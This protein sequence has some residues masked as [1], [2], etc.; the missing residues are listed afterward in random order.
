[1]LAR[2]RPPNRSTVPGSTARNDPLLTLLIPS[3]AHPSMTFIKND[4]TGESKRRASRAC[5]AEETLLSEFD[6]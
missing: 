6:G 3:T 2:I 4:H 1:M 5:A